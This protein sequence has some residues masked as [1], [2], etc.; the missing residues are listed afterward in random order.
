MSFELWHQGVK[1][2]RDNSIKVEWH[3]APPPPPRPVQMV[4]PAFD[5]S[6]LDLGRMPVTQHFGLPKSGT[7]FTAGMVNDVRV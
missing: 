5:V 2:S 6:T 7:V 3:A 4:N 1:L